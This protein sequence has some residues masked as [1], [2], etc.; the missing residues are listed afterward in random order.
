MR[1]LMRLIGLLLLARMLGLGCQKRV[2][3]KA[4]RRPK[5]TVRGGGKR[6]G[7]VTNFPKVG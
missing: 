4:S 3:H 7:M 6:I 2:K 1:E 5:Q